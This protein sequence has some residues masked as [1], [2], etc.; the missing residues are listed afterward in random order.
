MQMQSCIMN[1]KDSDMKKL[2]SYLLLSVFAFGAVAVYADQHKGDETEK[3]E[4]K[5]D[6]NNDGKVSYEEFKDAR[7]K[8]MDEHFKRRDTNGDGFIDAEE[9][10]AARTH[11]KEK[12]HNQ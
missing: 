12:R 6:V 11:K 10:K 4:M 3:H 1:I 8:H 2:L 7:M 5:A 9:R